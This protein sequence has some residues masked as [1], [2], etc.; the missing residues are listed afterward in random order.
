MCQARVRRSRWAVMVP[1]GS[2]PMGRCPV[3]GAI[4]MLNQVMNLL[5]SSF[6]LAVVRLRVE[7]SHSG[8]PNFPIGKSTLLGV[9]AARTVMAVAPCSLITQGMVSGERS[10]QA[11]L[12]LHLDAGQEDEAE[13]VVAGDAAAAEIEHLAGADAR[14]VADDQEACCTQAPR[15]G[16]Q[17]DDVGWL[18]PPCGFSGRAE[19]GDA[20]HVLFDR[21]AGG[22]QDLRAVRLAEHLAVD[23]PGEGQAGQVD[24][25]AVAAGDAG[26]GVAVPL[27]RSEEG[28]EPI[29][30][31]VPPRRTWRW[32]WQPQRGGAEGDQALDGGQQ[33]R[34]DC[35]DGEQ[36]G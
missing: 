33:V 24:D 13:L 15:E 31:A 6:R 29:G 34:G 22:G 8:R 16:D 2:W 19:R 20:E 17:L 11:G 7:V 4:S 3:T 28:G 9:I 10:R 25:G 21:Q 1:A 27:K 26:Q 14:Q 32:R 23:L 30:G 12:G 5:M 36:G 35:L 18:C